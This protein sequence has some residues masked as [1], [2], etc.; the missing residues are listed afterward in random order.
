M[1]L[2]CASLCRL[3]SSGALFFLV[4]LPVHSFGTDFTM[5]V[6]SAAESVFLSTCSRPRPRPRPRPWSWGA[7]KRE[8]IEFIET[9]IKNENSHA[10]IPM[11]A[12]PPAWLYR[13]GCTDI[14]MLL[15]ASMLSIC[16]KVGACFSLM[17]LYRYQHFHNLG[18]LCHF[19]FFKNLQPRPAHLQ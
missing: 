12:I 5:I 16:T 11:H 15:A 10:A 18:Y 19:A 13:L 4:F 3:K 1:I 7:G 8:P 17:H 14:S 2:P 6:K 9:N